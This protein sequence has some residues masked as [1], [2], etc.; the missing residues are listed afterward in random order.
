MTQNGKDYS[1]QLGLVGSLTSAGVL[2]VG[3]IFPF[4]NSAFAQS[5][6]TP[7]NTLGTEKS[8]VIN[9]YEDKAIEAIK[10][11]ATRDNN[12]FHSFLEFNVSEGR[13]AIFLSPNNIQN[14]L[15]RVTGS[16]RSDIM[17]QL[18]I[19]DSNANLFLINPNGISFG[20]NATLSING[21]FV[22][23]TA[24]G[25]KFMDGTVFSANTPQTIPL[26]TV[27]VPIGLQFGA[28][29]G[30]IYQE[31][32]LEVPTGKTLA[33]V[34]GNVTLDGGNISLD[35]NSLLA[36]NGQI[37]LGGILGVG[38]IGINLDS[39][40]QILSF[41]N[42]VALA[43]V[44]FRNQARID[45]SGE[46]GGYVQLQGRQVKL[47]DASQVVADTKGSQNGR[48]ISIQTEQ[49][50]L[51]DGSQVKASAREGTGSGG[52]LV[53]KAT[54]FVKVI[55]TVPIGKSN[56][57]NPSGLF[58]ETYS[59]GAAGELTIETGKLIVQD[60][61]NVTVS[62]RTGSQGN[63][64]KLKVTAAD[65][66]NISGTAPN[67]NEDPSGLFT[68]TEGIGNAGA[69]TI[70]TR[71]LLV[72]NGA[73]ISSATLK[74]SQG[75]GGTITINTSDSVELSGTS[76]IGKFPSGIFAQTLNIRNAGSV[77]MTTG[78]LIM[79]D[80]AILAVSARNGGKAG[81]LDITARDIRLD[82]KAQLTARTTSGKGGNIT[83]ELQ[84]LLL[85]RNQSQIST[86]AGTAT[87]GGDGGNITINTPKGF[88]V[89][90][91]SEN[92]D[93]SANAYTG[94][95]GNVTIKAFNLYGIKNRPKLTEFSDITASSEYGI[96][97]TVEINTSEINPS[98]GLIDLA[99][100]PGEPKLSQLCQGRAGRKENSFTITGRGGLPSNPLEPF[101]P[102]ASVTDWITLDKGNESFSNVPVTQNSTQSAPETIVEATGWVIN[103]KG[104]VVLTANAPTPESDGSWHKSSDCTTP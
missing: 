52:S 89:A 87:S 92:S 62:A 14:I 82:G 36:P 43:D 40:N 26:L 84:N 51:E 101:S 33:L 23:S 7:D 10:G 60:G 56:A 71:Q 73:V 77:S 98:Q 94:K 100:Q 57:G 80:G 9:N 79:R 29:G 59:E 96:N 19:M 17:G 99:A 5:V 6:I 32:K 67:R 24:S 64:G 93:I 27:S 53:V 42:D 85:L 81:N 95:G 44:S 8:Q 38:T 88:I 104:E 50:T 90:V 25:I 28:A 55:G 18:G 97:G 66:V 74:N 45:V 103:D 41:P 39:N 70:N 21:S 46:G 72:Q 16:N 47:T 11:G 20:R 65:L 61:G 12:L 34:G 15:V 3:I 69:L 35:R 4:S 30:E 83:L 58:A 102:D 54:D 37:A 48:G 1:W 49:L 22:A 2:V 78:Q 63:G 75:D 31:G 91:E 68:Q 86:T 13:S 76:A